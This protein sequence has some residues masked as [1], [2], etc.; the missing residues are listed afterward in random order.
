M[1]YHLEIV[2]ATQ[3]VAEFSFLSF[4]SIWTHN[5]NEGVTSTPR[6]HFRIKL[7]RDCPP[8]R[9]LQ[10]IRLGLPK[11][12]A[13][14]RARRKWRIVNHGRIRK[15]AM[16]PGAKEDK[17]DWNTLSSLDR[18]SHNIFPARSSHWNVRHSVQ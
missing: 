13:S 3:F 10:G 14:M 17:N 8:P 4:L 11:V 6:F 15:T 5:R 2:L 9:P 12:H 18:M 7:G 1:Q 16:A